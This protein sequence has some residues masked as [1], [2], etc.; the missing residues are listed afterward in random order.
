MSGDFS[1]LGKISVIRHDPE[2]EPAS[3]VESSNDVIICKN[4]DGII[5]SW[6]TAASRVFGYSAEEMIGN[7]ALRISRQLM[8]TFLKDSRASSKR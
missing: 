5:T 8:T 3:L 7:Y 1:C 4:L 2:H 6:N